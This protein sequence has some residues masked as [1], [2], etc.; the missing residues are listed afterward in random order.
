MHSESDIFIY[1]TSCVLVEIILGTVKVVFFF[2]FV[3]ETC[4]C[5]LIKHGELLDLLP[6]FLS[7]RPY[8]I[9]K[10]YKAH[11]TNV[12]NINFLNSHFN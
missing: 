11:L 4:I 12:I 3:H 1:S 5:S 8:L 2:S 10:A 6:L 7:N 9:L